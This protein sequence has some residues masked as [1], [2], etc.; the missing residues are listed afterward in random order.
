MITI[1]DLIEPVNETRRIE[2]RKNF[3]NWPNDVLSAASIYEKESAKL[4]IGRIESI[5]ELYALLGE[6]IGS[7]KT[8]PTRAPSG[9]RQNSQLPDADDAISDTPVEGPRAGAAEAAPSHTISIEELLEIVKQT[10]IRQSEPR[11]VNSL[12]G[13]LS[14]DMRQKAGQTVVK[15]RLPRSF[16][17]RKM[18]IIFW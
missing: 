16:Q 1:A 4:Y 18:R 13:V 11:F 5:R 10:P 12:D 6:K 7:A 8:L 17:R 2:R 3:A 14:K 9:Q 15:G